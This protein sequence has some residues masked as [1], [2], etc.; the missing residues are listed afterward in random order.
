MKPVKN[1]TGTLKHR[2]YAYA[3]MVTMLIVKERWCWCQQGVDERSS[4]ML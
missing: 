2:L 1:I 3:I 4:G